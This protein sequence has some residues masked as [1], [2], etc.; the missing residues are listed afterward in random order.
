MK[1]ENNM[2]KLIAL[3]LVVLCMISAAIPAMAA[4]ASIRKTEYEGSGKVEVD[5]KKDVQY[6]N[7]RAPRFS[8]S[9]LSF[10]RSS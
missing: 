9:A 7:V 1:G 4:S 2:R 5:F 10:S 6:K 3:A 8:Y